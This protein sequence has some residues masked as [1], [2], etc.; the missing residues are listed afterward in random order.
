MVNYESPLKASI[1]LIDDRI[2]AGE[3]SQKAGDLAAQLITEWESKKV[4]LKCTI[5]SFEIVAESE[6]AVRAALAKA[7][8]ES[9]FVVTIGG[10]GLRP[11]SVVPEVTKSLLRYELPGVATQILMQGL[12]STHKAGLSRGLVGVTPGGSLIVNA[13]K[14][15][16][17]VRDA[18]TVV[19]PLLPSIFEQI[20][21]E[22]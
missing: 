17:G 12:Q 14:S 4:H 2:L 18:L 19:L 13:P 3:R 20:D 22:G 8:A 11:N 15:T 21:E 5:Y 9:R 6:A 10:T 1:V 16:G 7:S